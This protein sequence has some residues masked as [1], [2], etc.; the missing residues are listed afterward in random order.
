MTV[1]ILDE[2]LW[3][4]FIYLFGSLLMASALGLFCCSVSDRL[5]LPALTCF[6]GGFSVTPFFIGTIM[7]LLSFIPIT[8]TRFVYLLF[9]YLIAAGILGARYRQVCAIL[10]R[11][12]LQWQKYSPLKLTLWIFFG[13]SMFFFLWFPGLPMNTLSWLYGESGTQIF[14]QIMIA[15]LVLALSGT[16]LWFTWRQRVKHLFQTREFRWEY[17]IS[18]SVMD[19]KVLNQEKKLKNEIGVWQL[20]LFYGVVVLGLLFLSIV[21][22]HTLDWRMP[23]FGDSISPAVRMVAG[24][25]SAG[26]LLAAVTA[27]YAHFKSGISAKGFYLCWICA[28]QEL[29]PMIVLFT[30]G[31]LGKDMIQS[32][33]SP[34]IGADANEYMS[35]AYLYVQSFQFK[36]IVLFQGTQSGTLIPLM[37]HPAWVTYLGNALL[38]NFTSQTG[39][40]NDFAVRLAIQLTYLYMFAALWGCTRIF[41]R[42]KSSLLSLSLP[43]L[44]SLFSYIYTSSGKDAFRLIPLFLLIPVMIGANAALK[45][46]LH[47]GTSITASVCVGAFVMM[48]H[49]INALA[50]VIIVAAVSIWLFCR[51]EFDRNTVLTYGATALGAL[52]GS[53]QMLW[54]L[55]ATGSLMG[56][57]YDMEQLLSGTPYLNN[58]LNYSAQRL[59]GTTN[60]WE[61]LLLILK[62]DYGLL[63]IAG[64]LTAAT[65]TVFSTH[66]L[67]R[68]REKPSRVF[69]L[70]LIGLLSALMLTDVVQWSNTRLS[71]WCVMNIRYTYQLYTFWALLLAICLPHLVDLLQKRG[72]ISGA[73]GIILV[74]IYLMLP[75]KAVQHVMPHYSTHQGSQF[76]SNSV[77]VEEYKQALYLDA[78]TEG[79]ALIDNYYMNYY[80][81]DKAL[82]LFSEAAHP[83]REAWDEEKLECALDDADISII[84]L[85]NALREVY[86]AN[87]P[88]EEYVLD[89]SYSELMFDG[90]Y[91]CVY[92]R[93]SSEKETFTT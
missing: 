85:T 12:W 68:Y 39:F 75:L 52:L 21:V 46:N 76:W 17:S 31:L 34:V 92:L 93:S 87:T 5:C 44:F 48:G 56:K 41:T 80:L 64:F 66:R 55:A 16:A 72:R 25:I 50:A 74:C 9:P 43:L 65:A 36:D 59:Q 8:L 45:I 77:V 91:I 54:A 3:C 49:P 70:A 29:V 2:Q 7:L 23:F 81:Q 11:F 84:I 53:F 73:A 71:E 86:W 67:L 37:H 79:R 33:Y 69:I 47:K 61:R 58:F 18:L 38:Y 20:S 57:S 60:Y 83:I 28:F 32:S 6:L 40:P 1:E 13:V 82:T 27:L 51:R 63:S 22:L 26:F 24:G 35:A 89:D 88:L 78:A 15:L 10:Q 19:K 30:L 90:E 62:R 42:K 4:Y 14:F